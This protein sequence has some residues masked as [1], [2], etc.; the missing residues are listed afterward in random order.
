MQIRAAIAA[1]AAAL[2]LGAAAAP[3]AKA[4]PPTGE[5]TGGFSLTPLASF[6]RPAYADN[7]PGTKHNLYVVETE[8]VVRVLSGSTVL[9]R[10]FLDISDMV[11]CCGEEGLLSIAFHPKYKKNRLFYVY[12]TDNNGD[13]AVWEFKRKKKRK[14]KFVALRSSARQVLVVPHPTNGNHNGGT[15]QFGPDGLLYVAT[16]D[17]GS[18]GDPPNNAQNPGSLLG[19]VLRIDPRKRGV[20]CKEPRPPI[21]RKKGAA[22]SG[23]RCAVSLPYT[24]P[25]DNP[26][27]AGGRPEVYSLGLRNPF[28]FSFDAVTGAISIGD[29]GQGCREEVNH[30]PKGAA[31]GANFGWSGF[32]GTRTFNAAR[33]APSVVFPI[34]EYDNSSAGGA[35]PPLGSA[36]DGVSV[37]A[38]FVVRD[39]RLAAQYGR[40]LYTDAANPQIRSVIPG[41]S[42]ADDRSTGVTA[43]GSVFAINEGF[44]RRLFV[45]TGDGP[46]YRVDPG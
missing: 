11:K 18:G 42:G 40:L 10:P 34:V 32:E 19:K 23:K 29:V 44:Q 43:P 38:G 35:C 6:D 9:P 27:R 4:A 37:I 5:G 1:G 46:V 15:I 12:F 17:G 28:R 13:N 26:Y 30:L 39:E 36:Y 33:I 22:A 21:K 2:A 31:R 16:G 41:P 7:A 45:V 8:G 24:S 25:K 20:K 14:A 3:A